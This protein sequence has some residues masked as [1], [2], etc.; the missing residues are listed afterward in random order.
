MHSS[1]KL[2]LEFSGWEAHT[3]FN[4]FVL[5][6]SSSILSLSSFSNSTL[7]DTIPIFYN[8]S[9]KV[10]A[11]CDKIVLRV[12]IVDVVSLPSLSI[13]VDYIVSLFDVYSIVNLTS[14]S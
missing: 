9:E 3:R 7:V 1:L 8:T 4:G 14:K 10:V 5:I 13:T 12:F 2:N 11:F 6:I